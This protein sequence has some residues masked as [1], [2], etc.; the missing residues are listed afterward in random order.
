MKEHCTR[1][2][3]NV[4]NGVL[5]KQQATVNSLNYMEE[6]KNVKKKVKYR[7]QKNI[8]KKKKNV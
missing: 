6:K 3:Q 8:K 5:K 7:R 2:I 4:K 1:K